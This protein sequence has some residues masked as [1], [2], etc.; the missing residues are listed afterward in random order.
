MVHDLGYASCSF[1]NGKELLDFLLNEPDAA[2]DLI[3]MD[4]VMPVMGGVEAFHQIRKAGFNTP[5]LFSSG[6]TQEKL[7]DLGSLDNIKL[8]YKPFTLKELSTKL[9]ELL[10]F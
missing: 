3:L 10:S 1:Q 4:V 5:V 2:I 8:M 7:A 6:Y 9:K